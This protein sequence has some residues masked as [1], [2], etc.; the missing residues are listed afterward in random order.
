[1]N[2]K[3]GKRGNEKYLLLI[4]DE[5]LWEHSEITKDINTEILELIRESE[6]KGG[7]KMRFAKKGQ[8]AIILIIAVVLIVAV[9]AFLCFE[10]E[11]RGVFLL[12]LLL[13]MIIIRRVFS[14]KRRLL[15]I[16]QEPGGYV[17]LPTY[18]PGSEY[19]P[20]SSQ[21]NF[22]DL[23][24]HIDDN[25]RNGIVKE[26]VPTK[27]EMEKEINVYFTTSFRL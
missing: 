20:F 11:R 7:K 10:E 6:N 18:V 22:L 4:E 8:L 27:Q 2:I 26:Q 25:I 1:M 14:R 3:R 19:A 21:L 23:E 17:F 15:Q 24:S 13:C 16:L 12:N 9:I 5:V